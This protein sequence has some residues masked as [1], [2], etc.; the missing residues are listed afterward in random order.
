MLT[1]DLKEDATS[2][3][4]LEYLIGQ[5]AFGRV[6]VATN[7]H[8]GDRVAIKILDVER[9]ENNIEILRRETNVL[10]KCRSPHIAFYYGSYVKDTEVWIVMEFMSGG[11]VLNLRRNR[12]LNEKEITSILRDTLQALNYLQNNRLIHRDVK[13]ENILLSHK[14]VAKLADFGEAVELNESTGRCH[15]M[16]GSPCWM[17]AD[18]WSLGITTIEMATGEPPYSGLSPNKV[19]ELVRNNPPPKLNGIWSSSLKEFVSM[20]LNLKPENASRLIEIRRIGYFSGLLLLFFYKI[21]F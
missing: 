12:P 5:G 9:P 2:F 13:A 19:L 11:S 14:N 16:A 17:A 8:S 15:S 10:W 3:Y 6:Y 20:C 4:T 21:D 1:D 18:I 7:S